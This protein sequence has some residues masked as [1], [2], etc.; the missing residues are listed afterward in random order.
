MQTVLRY[1]SANCPWHWADN[2]T[3]WE[4][5]DSVMFWPRIRPCTRLGCSE[6][7]RRAA[8]S[9]YHQSNHYSWSH[10]CHIVILPLCKENFAMTATAGSSPW[11]PW[12]DYLLEYSHNDHDSCVSIDCHWLS[13]WS[14]LAA[15]LRLTINSKSQSALVLKLNLTLIVY[16][17]L[18]PSKTQASDSYTSKTFRLWQPEHERKITSDCELASWLASELEFD[19]ELPVPTLKRVS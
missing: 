5:L 17:G 18:G 14:A 7:R 4:F 16:A 13:V 9:C 11:Q 3:G 12:L 10:K 6:G 15:G 2:G 8:G 19:S 1:S